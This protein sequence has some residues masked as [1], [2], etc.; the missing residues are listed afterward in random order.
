MAVLAASTCSFST[1]AH[2]SRTA[3]TLGNAWGWKRASHRIHKSVKN[4]AV[5][6]GSF[7]YLSQPHSLAMMCTSASRT[8]RNQ[9]PVNEE[10]P[11]NFD[12]AGFERQLG[13]NRSQSLQRYNNFANL[14]VGLHVAVRFDNI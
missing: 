5:G 6:D 9:N 11:V 3:A 4:A 8:E 13:P 1:S 10:L 7:Q 2:L 12:Y 14:L